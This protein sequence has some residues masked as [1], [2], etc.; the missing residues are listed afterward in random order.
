MEAKICWEEE[1]VSI[2]GVRA[3]QTDNSLRI[4]TASK[5]ERAAGGRDTELSVEDDGG[6]MNVNDRFTS[7]SGR[8]YSV[9]G[10]RLDDAKR[11]AGETERVL[12]PRA[13]TRWH[14]TWRQIG[15]EKGWGK[16]KANL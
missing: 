10:A 11:R 9:P 14:R 4:L 2:A 1:R 5:G 3:T 16:I 7:V 6:V 12:S 13:G 8:G 15:E